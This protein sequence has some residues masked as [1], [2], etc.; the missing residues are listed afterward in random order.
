MN[1][2]TFPEGPDTQQLP[3]SQVQSSFSDV[4]GAYGAEAWDQNPTPALLRM[5][6][7]AQAAGKADDEILSATQ[8]ADEYGLGG[9]LKFEG[10]TRRGLAEQLSNQKQRTL[11]IE[12]TLTRREPGM[13]TRAAGFA[14]GAAATMADPAN[15]G[16]ALIPVVGEGN[17]ARIATALGSKIAARTVRGAAEGAVAIGLGEPVVYFANQDEQN[18]YTAAD[19]MQKVLYGAAGGAVLHNF[20]SGVSDVAKAA[21]DRIS[22]QAKESAMRATI[23]EL[24]QDQPV[25]AF[26]KILETDDTMARAQAIAGRSLT[27][28]EKM[29]VVMGKQEMPEQMKQA[30]EADPTAFTSYVDQESKN[31]QQQNITD[32]ENKT[33]SQFETDPLAATEVSEQPKIDTNAPAD[34]QIAHLEQELSS[35]PDYQLAPDEEIPPELKGALDEKT[36][37]DALEESFRQARDCIYASGL[38]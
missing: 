13:L 14:V 3:W 34:E 19:S 4:M 7:H 11:Q 30:A 32:L 21:Y 6:E 15:I 36:R 17:E 27:E 22:P 20:F 5:M 1:P 26:T 12:D 23:S 8:A 16:L 28:Q 29:D 31:I 24:V 18:D 37:V 33:R 35:H 25:D 38:I 2:L 9:A 10:P